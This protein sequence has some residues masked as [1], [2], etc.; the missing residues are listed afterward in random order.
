MRSFTVSLSLRLSLREDSKLFRQMLIISSRS[1]LPPDF[2]KA[3]YAGLHDLDLDF[4]GGKAFP[5]LS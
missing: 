3:S 4:V 2:V 5:A 1:I